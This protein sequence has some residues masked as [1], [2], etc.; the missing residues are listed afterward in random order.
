ME[1]M[2]AATLMPQADSWYMGANIPGK[3][4]QMLFYMSSRGYMAHCN[5]S[6]ARGYTGFRL[7]DGN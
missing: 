2:G 5:D 1:E 6:A 4:R 7:S 3:R